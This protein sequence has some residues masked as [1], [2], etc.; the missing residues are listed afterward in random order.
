MTYQEKI[1][2]TALHYIISNFDNVVENY[3]EITDPEYKKSLYTSLL[4]YSHQLDKNGCVNMTYRHSE[5]MKTMGRRF[6]T[7]PSLQTF[8]RCIRNALSR[9]Y[10]CDLDME[11]AHPCILEWYC[12]T[13]SI[14][15]TMLSEYVKD[16]TGIL[17]R[18]QDV[19]KTDRDSVKKMLLK[20]INGGWLTQEEADTMPK[21]V[22]D[23][24]NEMSR[25]REKVCELNSDL[26]ELARKGGR[27]YNIDGSATNYLMCKWEDKLLAI[28]EKAVSEQGY[29][30]GVLAFDGLMIRKSDPERLVSQDQGVV[31]V[32]EQRIRNEVGINMNLKFKEM[33]E[34]VPCGPEGGDVDKQTLCELTLRK[35][36]TE[37]YTLDN[38][39][40][41]RVDTIPE[42][43]KWCRDIEFPSGYRSI[44]INLR[45]GGGKTSACIRYIDL[46][47]PKRVLIISPRQT[48]AQS[49]TGEYNEKLNSEDKF[50]C[51]LNVKNKGQLNRH[52]RLCCS[53]ESLHYLND[54][55]WMP[56]LVIQD[57]C[58]A[59]FTQHT[60]VTTNS[61][62]IDDNMEVYNKF[63]D[64]PNTRVIFADA[65]M[66]QK[67]I[68]FINHKRLP[69]VIYDYKCKMVQRQAIEVKGR[70]TKD[71]DV[72]L[73]VLKK[74]LINGERN[75][76]FVSSK[77]RLLKWVTN[78]RKEFPTKVFL[79]YTSGARIGNVRDEWSQADCV[80]T[81][82]TISVG[83][84]YD[85]QGVFNNVFMYLSSASQNRICDAFQSHY[86]V[87][88]LIDN[89][90]YYFLDERIFKRLNTSLYFL[91]QSFNWKEKALIDRLGRFINSPSH[92][93]QL[94]IDNQYEQNMSSMHLRPMFNYFLDA[95]NYDRDN[96]IKD[97]EKVEIDFD[98]VGADGEDLEFDE[99][100]FLNA[101]EA[102]KLVKKQKYE[103]LTELER[104]QLDK[105]FFGSC[106]VNPDTFLPWAEQEHVEELWALWCNFGR[107]KIRQ[108]RKERKVVE[109]V[110]TI[111][112]YLDD[113]AKDCQVAGLNNKRVL[114]IEFIVNIT[115]EMGLKHSHDVETTIPH[116]V[117]K[118]MNDRLQKEECGIRELFDLQNRKTKKD[119][120][121]FEHMTQLINSIFKTYGFTKM[122]KGKR[123][124]YREG[125]KFV[126]VSDYK[127]KSTIPRDTDDTLVK[128]LGDYMLVKKQEKE[129]DRG[130][131]NRQRAMEAAGLI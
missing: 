76:V 37:L 120:M 113:L 89:K 125:G 119:E 1:S 127:L 122:V 6:S 114:Q 99:I 86:R 115:R 16:R 54:K 69:T 45:L 32:I 72:M 92:L 80:L 9:D 18:L 101:F 19:M 81:T 75:Y 56:D 36:I 26:V 17:K 66:G 77:A 4:N 82:S 57:E 2:I 109:G 28:V 107:G 43:E 73:T 103:K 31:C 98:D 93:K 88:H 8:P 83:V 3:V 29:S 58:Q 47:A 30:V 104:L 67:T 34:A 15:C 65:F 62:H 51:Y 96:D 60:S 44:G 50:V 20:Y 49:I 90:L 5:N 105:Y 23:F 70:N 116:S 11:N 110:C 10:Y 87:R 46:T 71:M 78:L 40:Y 123:K 84:N 108:F 128:A 39:D 25:I 91:T 100:P 55:N 124:R 68:N 7:G 64:N 106:F 117:L 42:E 129:M 24:Y 52:N 41:I 53:M 12:K 61:K 131:I 97:I 38:S 33:D 118:K 130:A 27:L 14:P 63:I 48:Y 35:K 126:D 94:I 95:C 111:R 79:T 121:N 13:N 59:S 22:V 112:D 74:S 21:W 102:G 85:I